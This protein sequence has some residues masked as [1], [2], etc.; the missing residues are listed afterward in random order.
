[1][2]TA[3]EPSYSIFPIAESDSVRKSVECLTYF[4]SYLWEKEIGSV[5][6]GAQIYFDEKRD[7][8][9]T[10]CALIHFSYPTQTKEV[11]KDNSRPVGG[12]L[13]RFM[14]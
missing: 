6:N 11:W 7:P 9:T 10:S 5:W 14:V 4:F 13:S 3:Q 12:S 2:Q 8:F 1:M